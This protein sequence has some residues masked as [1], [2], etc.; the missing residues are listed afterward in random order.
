MTTTDKPSWQRATEIIPGRT[1]SWNS[2]G[3]N[4]WRVVHVSVFKEARAIIAVSDDGAPAVD[5]WPPTVFPYEQAPVAPW[6]VRTEYREPKAGELYVR[7]SSSVIWCSSGGIPAP[8]VVVIIEP[9]PEY[10]P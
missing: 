7:H 1:Y 5:M 4:P 9:N 8:R 10:Q 6:I 2:D 3:G